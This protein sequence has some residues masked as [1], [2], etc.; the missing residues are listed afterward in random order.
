ME[1]I[2]NDLI[3]IWWRLKIIDYGN[4]FS[5]SSSTALQKYNA[6]M[7]QVITVAMLVTTEVKANKSVYA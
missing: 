7:Q 6:E 1:P 2:T 4:Q 3:P 5:D